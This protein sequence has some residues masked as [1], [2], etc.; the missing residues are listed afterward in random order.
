MPTLDRQPEALM[1]ELLEALPNGWSCTP[2]Y[3]PGDPSAEWYDLD[4]RER[5]RDTRPQGVHLRPGEEIVHDW[6]LIFT[7]EQSDR[8][9]DG[10]FVGVLRGPGGAHQ[11][12]AHYRNM[13]AEPAGLFRRWSDHVPAHGIAHWLQQ[14]ARATDTDLIERALA[15][16]RRDSLLGKRWFPGPSVLVL[17]TETTG[18]YTDRDRVVELAWLLADHAP[19]KW[20]SHLINPGVP[21]PA[22][23]YTVNGIDDSL[24]H[25][26]GG[27]PAQTLDHALEAIAEHLREGAVL[28]VAN[29]EFDL[30]LLDAECRRHSLRP[31]AARVGVEH[32]EAI[33]PIRIHQRLF[34]ARKGHS[35]IPALA[36]LYVSG[37]PIGSHTALGDCHATLHIL[38]G[39]LR[40]EGERIV[41]RVTLDDAHRSISGNHTPGALPR[42][43]LHHLL[44]LSRS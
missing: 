23:A 28:V 26:E 25:A 3:A 41:R 35:T 37:G 20:R 18:T 22:D 9:I 14:T 31:L 17:D 42:L 21:M 24:L 33:D 44:A 12:F 8:T 38:V 43:A 27:S 16:E 6:R 4:M 11:L 29:A 32:L 1:D 2:D 15:E 7:R 30:E 34:G 13:D 5:A 39:L 36:E 10:A 19:R 40:Q